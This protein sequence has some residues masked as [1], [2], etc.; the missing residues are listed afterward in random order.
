MWAYMAAWVLA[1]FIAQAVVLSD[2]LLQHGD[3]P[4]WSLYGPNDSSVTV[5]MDAV[6]MSLD[7]PWP[8]HYVPA[9]PGGAVVVLVAGFLLLGYPLAGQGR[10]ETQD[11]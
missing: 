8:P 9:I 4:A 5:T 1:C 10:D 3:E 11:A 6:M 2:D 7:L